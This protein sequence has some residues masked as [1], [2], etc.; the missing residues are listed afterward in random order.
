ML[1]TVERGRLLARDRR[2]AAIAQ[3]TSSAAR[4]DCGCAALLIA[5]FFGH[6]RG[7]RLRRP[8]VVAAP[9]A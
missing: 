1:Q 9:I 5:L 7:S 3:S 6:R 8:K 2:I 4:N